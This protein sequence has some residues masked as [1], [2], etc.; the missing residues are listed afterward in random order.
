MFERRVATNFDWT[1]FWLTYA[2]ALVG[3]VNLVSASQ[4]DAVRQVQ[5]VVIGSLLMLGFLVVDY[6]F[7]G[8][9]AY[10]GYALVLAMLAGVLLF[11][12]SGGGAQRW[13]VDLPQQRDR[14]R[15]LLPHTLGKAA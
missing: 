3:I 9:A 14:D 2:I 5:W 1:L 10:F 4:P 13:A 7:V 15:D 11:G 6:H 12:R 8:R